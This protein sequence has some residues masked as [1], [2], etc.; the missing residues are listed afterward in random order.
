MRVPTVE[1]DLLGGVSNEC[2]S[3]WYQ[4]M[5]EEC[6]FSGDTIQSAIYAQ[7]A[8]TL[9]THPFGGV[10]SAELEKFIAKWRRHV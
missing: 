4:F 6:Y 8:E 5:S 2:A 10:H 7:R 9:R 1:R 3:Q